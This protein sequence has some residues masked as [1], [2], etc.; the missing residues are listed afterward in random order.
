MK[1]ITKKI[2]YALTTAALITAA[3]VF[4]KSQTETVIETRITQPDKYNYLDLKSVTATEIENDE[5]VIYT[6]SG[7]YY[8]F[9]LD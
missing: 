4:G 6:N 9:D 3:F 7:D 8:T 2:I 5:V 1:R